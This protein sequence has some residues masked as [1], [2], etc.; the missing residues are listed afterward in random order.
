MK[1]LMDGS[2]L[3][4]DDDI[5]WDAFLRAPEETLAMTATP[6]SK[7][8]IAGTYGHVQIAE[9]DSAQATSNTTERLTSREIEVLRLMADGLSTKGIASE[10][11]V[12]FKTAACHRYHLLQKLGCASTVLAVRWAIRNGIAPL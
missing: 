8:P 6:L 7:A 9:S 1:L 2:C 5:K 12:T 4:R 11:G 3:R 10:L